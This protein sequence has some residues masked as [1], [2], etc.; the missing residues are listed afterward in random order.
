MQ[1]NVSSIKTEPLRDPLAE[2]S[3]DSYTD[4]SFVEDRQQQYNSDEFSFVKTEPEEFIPPDESI[5]EDEDV[6]EEST[7]ANRKIIKVEPREPQYESDNDQ[8]SVNPPS[9]MELPSNIK[10]EN[11]PKTLIVNGRLVVRGAQLQSLVKNFYNLECKICQDKI[12][13]K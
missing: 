1:H 11:I 4:G 13:Y 8:D 6:A 9:W 5:D 10:Q 2:N 12:K 7:L 3:W